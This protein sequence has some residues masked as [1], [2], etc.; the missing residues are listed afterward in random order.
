MASW[1]LDPKRS[2]PTEVARQR[3]ALGSDFL[4]GEGKSRSDKGRVCPKQDW[5]G[6]KIARQIKGISR[7]VS[8]DKH[9]PRIAWCF[10]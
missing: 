10:Y 7:T 4:A 8:E 6:D 9:L 3:S 2:F 1:L 5:E